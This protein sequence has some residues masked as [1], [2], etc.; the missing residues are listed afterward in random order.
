LNHFGLVRGF[1]RDHLVGCPEERLIEPAAEWS[2]VS[3]VERTVAVAGRL[4][5][6]APR[7]DGA[8]GLVVSAPL[9]PALDGSSILQESGGSALGEVTALGVVP[10]S[11]QPRI[12]VGGDGRIAL[13]PF[14]E[15]Q[16]G[17]SRWETGVGFRAAMIA[18]QGGAIWAAG[19][20]R[21]SDRDDYDWEQLSGGGYA[22]L[23]PAD[24][25]AIMSG[26]LPEDV[27]WGTGGAALV[28][29]GSL[30]AAIG[31]RGC[32][33]LIDPRSGATRSTAPLASASL[34]IG[35][36]AAVGRQLLCGFNRGGY[37]LHSF[38]ESATESEGR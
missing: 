32:L 25:T 19:P 6:S 8:I 28:P 13:V 20:Q 30:L 22:V 16:I 11:S 33:H 12:A 9:D 29:F 2:F 17:R 36:L 3:D 14:A 10:P 27:A 31:R 26:L 1:G 24:G 38:S 15:G 18:W 5:G 35:H 37:R 21:G 4:V 7:S 23:D 34:G